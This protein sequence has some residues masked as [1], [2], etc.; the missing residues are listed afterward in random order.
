[1]AALLQYVLAIVS[2]VLN[3]DENVSS[4]QELDNM[5]NL[6]KHVENELNDDENV[7]MEYC[8]NTLI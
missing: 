2:S 3:N 4:K 5:G 1:M 6:L 8:N 7:L